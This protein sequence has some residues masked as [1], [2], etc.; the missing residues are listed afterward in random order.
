MIV[1]YSLGVK[2]ESRWRTQAAARSARTKQ[3][4]E[5]SVVGILVPVGILS[6]HFFSRVGRSFVREHHPYWTEPSLHH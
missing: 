6:S 5:N 3:P 4:T 1:T 2:S